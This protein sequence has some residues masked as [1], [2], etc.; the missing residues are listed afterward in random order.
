MATTTK[1]P[2]RSTREER[3][4]SSRS[5][6]TSR[7]AR[8]G[9]DRG[10]NRAQAPRITARNLRGDDRGWLES[11]A[12]Q[13]SPSTLRAKWIHSPDEHE[14][15]PGQTLATREPDVIRAWAEQRDAQ[16]A[17]VARRDG[18]RPRTLRFDFGGSGGGGRSS[19]LEPITWEDWLGTYQERELVFLFQEHRRNGEDS[20]F[21]RLDSP[22]RED[23]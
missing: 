8:S 22:E 10:S 1:R 4:T 13:L 15:R 14:D 5:T 2:S 18:Q 12:E 6:R 11:R 21:F 20:N 3:G 19:R 16:P 7:P 23:G 17:T 9:G